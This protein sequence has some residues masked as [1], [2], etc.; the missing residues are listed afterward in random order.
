[1]GAPRV[2]LAGPVATSAGHSDMTQPERQHLAPNTALL[3]CVDAY[4][5]GR[6]GVGTRQLLGQPPANSP[7]SPVPVP[8]VTV[9]RAQGSSPQAPFVAVPVGLGVGNRQ[10]S[11]CQ[12][13]PGDTV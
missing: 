13:F 3:I 4:E 2:P 6:G 8:M 5:Y 10:W 1:M 12:D 7:A 9:A 11:P